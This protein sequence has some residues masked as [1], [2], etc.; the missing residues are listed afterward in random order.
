MLYRQ[1]VP[2]AVGTSEAASPQQIPK[3]AAAAQIFLTL[4]IRTSSRCAQEAV[5]LDLRGSL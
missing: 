3:K 5:A 2:G 1:L 4:V